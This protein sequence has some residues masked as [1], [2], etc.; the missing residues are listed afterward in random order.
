MYGLCIER[1]AP[2]HGR[3]MDI[4]ITSHSS[5]P[6]PFCKVCADAA[7]P[8][9]EGLL[10]C[11]HRLSPVDANVPRRQATPSTAKHKPKLSVREI[12][13]LLTWLRADSKSEVAE[14]LGLRVG[15][16][17]THITRITHEVHQRRAART[18]QGSTVR[19]RRPGLVSRP[20]TNGDSRPG[21]S[22][23]RT[24]FG[25]SHPGNHDGCLSVPGRGH[26]R[27]DRR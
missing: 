21:E 25:R 2:F 13:V 23:G 17:N 8:P 18:D 6:Q 15:T 16:V 22:S 27:P 9:L 7:L 10:A 11:L 12:E 20:S 24:G 3:L 14:T 1:V 4:L 19:A 5:P 26:R